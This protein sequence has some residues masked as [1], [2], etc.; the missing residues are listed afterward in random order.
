MANNLRSNPSLDKAVSQANDPDSLRQTLHNFYEAAGVL[1]RERGDE[2]LAS[3]QAPAAA[4]APPLPSRDNFS[5]STRK[6]IYPYGNL[7]LEISGV[8]DESLAAVEERIR[9][10][11]ERQ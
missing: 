1:H 3:Q 4:V 9:Q 10:A 5:Q 2:Y 11:F 8:D 6:V 7:R